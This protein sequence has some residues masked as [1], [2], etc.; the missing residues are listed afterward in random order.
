MISSQFSQYLL[1]YTR[2]QFV[3]KGLTGPIF[4]QTS[5]FLSLVV[6]PVTINALTVSRKRRGQIVPDKKKDVFLKLLEYSSMRECA[7]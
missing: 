5:I 4:C 2:P 7:K 3:L 1:T 6:I